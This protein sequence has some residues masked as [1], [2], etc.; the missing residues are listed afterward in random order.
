[1]QPTL[2]QDDYV[3][4]WRWLGTQ[5]KVGDIIV[6]HHPTLNIIIKR[7]VQTDPKLGYL[8]AGDNPNST[9]VSQLGWVK[10][11]ALIGKVIHKV[12]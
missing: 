11:E 5:F 2:K 7:I 8:I 6:T 10:K 1:M 12:T 4:C 3:F 9:P